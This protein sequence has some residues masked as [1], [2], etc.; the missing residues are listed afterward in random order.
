MVVTARKPTTVK[1]SP[2]H[3]VG[4]TFSNDQRTKDA[5]VI[6]IV[7]ASGTRQFTVHHPVGVTPLQDDVWV[8]SE[9]SDLPNL[10]MRINDPTKKDVDARRDASLRRALARMNVIIL[11]GDRVFYPNR[12]DRSDAI[13]VARKKAETAKASGKDAYVSYLSDED[14]KYETA[15]LE[16]IRNKDLQA[17][18]VEK[19]PYA[20][21]ETKGGVSANRSQRPVDNSLGYS[22]GELIDFLS[23]KIEG[24]TLP[25]RTLPKSGGTTV[26]A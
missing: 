24:L 12:V 10:L 3:A 7:S 20:D 17:G 15:Y 14:K 21:F 23:Q 8:V 1:I 11:E 9:T 18:I 16:A 6:M 4:V 13:S 22:Q 2:T 26:H 5:F 25:P 19:Y